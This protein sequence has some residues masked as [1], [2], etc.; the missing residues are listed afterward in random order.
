MSQAAE[1]LLSPLPL[2]H[3][4]ACEVYPVA[5]RCSVWGLIVAKPSAFGSGSVFVS[6]QSRGLF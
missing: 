2:L 4:D 1:G 5:L 6:D 3:P